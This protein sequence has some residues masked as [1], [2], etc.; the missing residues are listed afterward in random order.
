MIRLFGRGGFGQ[1]WE[2]ESLD[3]DRRVAVKVLTEIAAADEEALQRFHQEGR[4]PA[5]LSHLNCVY[6]FG[7]QQMKGG[8]DPESPARLPA[9]CTATVVALCGTVVLAFCSYRKAL[10]PRASVSS[11]WA[12]RNHRGGSEITSGQD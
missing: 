7:A 5:S 11:S 3:T 9:G 8:A 2:A 12:A 4:L 1:V 10:G 6:L